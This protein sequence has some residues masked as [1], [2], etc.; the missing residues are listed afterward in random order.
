MQSWDRGCTTDS[1]GGD[2]TVAYFSR[3]LNKHQ[4]GYFTVE[5]EAL[6]LVLAVQHF[7]LYLAGGG[8][9]LLIITLF[10]G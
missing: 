6:T 2:T 7:E 4:K 10:L 5:K 9:L 8:L 1:A 3:K